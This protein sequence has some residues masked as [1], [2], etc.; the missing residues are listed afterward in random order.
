[1]LFSFRIS[2]DG[3]ERGGSGVALFNL[4]R[5]NASVVRISEVL[6]KVFTYHKPGTHKSVTM[7]AKSFAS[8][9]LVTC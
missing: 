9:C 1:V 2:R 5:I 7:N 6:E 4:E 3:Q 8:D